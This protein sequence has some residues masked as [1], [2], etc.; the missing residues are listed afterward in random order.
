LRTIFSPTS[1]QVFDFVEEEI[2]VTVVHMTTLK[3]YSS[4]SENPQQSTK[5]G[6]PNKAQEEG[7][8]GNVNAWLKTP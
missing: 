6:T 3:I 4:P 7:D 2:E 8:E 5:I 1:Y